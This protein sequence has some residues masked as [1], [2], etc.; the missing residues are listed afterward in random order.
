MK[1][2]PQRVK[3]RFGWFGRLKEKRLL[4]VEILPLECSLS[5]DSSSKGFGNAFL[6]WF[7]PQ[8]G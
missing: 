1:S 4:P 3:L 2:D 6:I 8:A 7:A 5:P